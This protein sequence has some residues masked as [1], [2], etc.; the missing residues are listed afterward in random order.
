VRLGEIDQAVGGEDAG[1]FRAAVRAL[2]A[3]DQEGGGAGGA[4][5]RRPAGSF[6]SHLHI[7]LRKL[8]ICQGFLTILEIL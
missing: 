3:G 4:G 7:M 1:D 6:G 5:P 2:Q 8:P